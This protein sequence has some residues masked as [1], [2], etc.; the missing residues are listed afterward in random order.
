MSELL[1]QEDFL[2]VDSSIPGQNYVCLSFLSPE[3]VLANKN[4]FYV[5]KF[6]ETIAKNYDLDKDTIQEK[7]KDFLYLNDNKLEQEFY[8]DNDFRTTMRGLKVR[9]VYDT[10]KEANVRA[11]ILQK[12]DKNFNVFVG[13]VGYWLPWDPSSHQIENQEYA[14]GELNNL[15]KEYRANSESKDQHF[16][17]NIDYAKQQAELQK[18]K[19]EKKLSDNS[20]NIINNNVNE[21]SVDFDKNDP[22]IQKKNESKN[23]K[24]VNNI[25]LEN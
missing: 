19:I 25:N 5:H 24:S 13:Q 16:Q 9:G 20:S 22:W 17:E 2:E 12:K 21:N 4:I 14:E 1:E 10:A 18:N 23:S 7:Y 6:L 3:E 8:K 15:M 11:K